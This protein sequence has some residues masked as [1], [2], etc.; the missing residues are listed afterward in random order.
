MAAEYVRCCCDTLAW[1]CYGSRQSGA[2]SKPHAAVLFPVRLSERWRCSDSE[3]LR[4]H[5]RRH[6]S[7]WNHVQQALPPGHLRSVGLH[8]AVC[9]GGSSPHCVRGSERNP[10]VGHSWK[11]QAEAGKSSWTGRRSPRYVSEPLCSKCMSKLF[12]SRSPAKIFVFSDHL[13][14]LIHSTCWVTDLRF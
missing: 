3:R 12:I 1:C 10:E 9:G 4:S 8:G 7:Y 14:N 13:N 11:E 5:C 6:G 2:A